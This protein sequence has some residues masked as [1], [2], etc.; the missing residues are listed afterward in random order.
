MEDIQFIIDGPQPE[1]DL[2]YPYT[3]KNEDLNF[4]QKGVKLKNFRENMTKRNLDCEFKVK[5][6]RN[7]AIICLSCLE[8][9]LKTKCIQV[10]SEITTP[11]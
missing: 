7:I 2:S 4:I 3:E 1:H 9:S 8:D 11:R 5:I 10:S 6:T